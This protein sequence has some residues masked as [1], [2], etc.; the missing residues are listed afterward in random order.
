MSAAARA[1]RVVCADKGVY[2]ELLEGYPG[3]FKDKLSKVMRLGWGIEPDVEDV[4]VDA[5]KV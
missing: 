5:V 1:R 2:I 3:R 4:R